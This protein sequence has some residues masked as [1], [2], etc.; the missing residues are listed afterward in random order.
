MFS[1][2]F[3]SYFPFPEWIFKISEFFWR[4]LVFSDFFQDWISYFSG[5]LL[6][7]FPDFFFTFQEEFKI[8]GLL[9]WPFFFWFSYLNLRTKRPQTSSRF[10][11][12]FMPC[13]CWVPRCATSVHQTWTRALWC[14]PFN[15]ETGKHAWKHVSAGSCT[16]PRPVSEN[17]IFP[18]SAFPVTFLVFRSIPTT[19]NLW[20]VCKTRLKW[21]IGQNGKKM[22]SLE[23]WTI[24]NKWTILKKKEKITEQFWNKITI[25]KKWIVLKNGKFRKMS[26]FGS[27]CWQFRKSDKLKKGTKIDE[28]N[29][30]WKNLKKNR[31]V[32]ARIS[33]LAL[34]KKAF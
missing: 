7:H 32:E 17:S 4:F 29:K 10:D 25:L 21:V 34:K 3:F 19:M 14:I 31:Y 12:L 15:F 1:Y 6:F 9:D 2:F 18:P 28:F 13:W 5:L 22:T 24:L 16:S 8:S 33:M 27:D 30:W 20:F 23:K 26:I 11:V